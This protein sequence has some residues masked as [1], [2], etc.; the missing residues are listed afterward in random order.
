MSLQLPNGCRI[1]KIG[2]HPKN[3]EN[4]DADVSIEWYIHYR[5]HDPNFVDKYPDGA[6]VKVRG[7]NYISAQA[8][9]RRVI[10]GLLDNEK[11]RLL[12]GY[13][14]ILKRI[15]DANDLEISP[16]TPFPNALEKAY[17]LLPSSKSKKEVR[18]ALP[19]IKKA[20]VLLRYS[21]I[22]IGQVR[23][24][25]V[26]AI[27][28][29]I[30]RTKEEQ[31]KEWG[32]ASYNHYRSYLI[33]LFKQLDICE[34]VE[35][36]LEKVPIRKGIKRR[37]AVPSDE[38]MDLIDQEM[39]SKFYTFWRF[40]HIFHRSGARMAELML[41]RKENVDLK[42]R[43]VYVVVRKRDGD[44][45]E[46]A[47]TITR[48]VLSL[49]QEIVDEAKPG[50][51]LFARG[52]RPAPIPINEHQVTKR[53]RIHV[54]KKLG[55]TADFYSLKK[56]NTTEVISRELEKIRLAQQVAA[57]QNSHTSTAMVQKHYDDLNDERLHN[58]L[59]AI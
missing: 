9:R 57:T 50:E 19:H 41:V 12:E 38:D 22:P 39:R 59:R 33:M 16:D 7:M 14:P 15:V 31:G 28:A 17:Q 21:A 1:G 8:D 3:W 25:Q 44:A 36:N 40:I 49:W 27:L 6:L 45:A 24:K 30:S 48:D 46:V 53:W 43:K 37:R 20:L 10:K 34:A 51:Y 5:F 58:Q 4:P 26:V 18:K 29:K 42:N 55:I 23:R 56:K 52:L 13:N 35:L 32:A 47:K 2:M 11:K 54:K